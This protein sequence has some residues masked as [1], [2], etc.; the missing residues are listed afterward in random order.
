MVKKNSDETSWPRAFGWLAFWIGL[1]VGWLALM[2]WLT[3]LSNDRYYQCPERRSPETA[4]TPG[5]EKI[6]QPGRS[7]SHPRPSQAR[8]VRMEVTAYCPCRRCC[9]RWADVPM[10][11]RT[12]ASGDRLDKLMRS[13]TRFCAADRSVP[14][15]TVVVVPGYGRAVVLDRGGAIK[16]D[17]LDLFFPTHAE[18]LRWGRRTVEVEMLKKSSGGK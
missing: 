12:T 18:A 8:M 10:S 6:V 7:Q 14:F 9:G 1:M 11:R 13:G 5:P 17:R 4:L 16:G 3:L 15:G 2:W